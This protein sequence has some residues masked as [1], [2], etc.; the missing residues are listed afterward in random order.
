MCTWQ[1]GSVGLIWP[2]YWCSRGSGNPSADAE[3][4]VENSRVQSS[5]H[6]SFRSGRPTLSFRGGEMVTDSAGVFSR[7]T[8]PCSK[9]CKP[10]HTKGRRQRE[11]ERSLSSTS[12][13]SKR[14]EKEGRRDGLEGLQFASRQIKIQ[15][16]PH[17]GTAKPHFT[18]LDTICA[19]RCG[20]RE[21]QYTTLSLLFFW[22]SNSAKHNCLILSSIKYRRLNSAVIKMAMPWHVPAATVTGQWPFT[23]PLQLNPEKKQAT[24]HLHTENEI[25]LGDTDDLDMV[26]L[27]ENQCSH[28]IFNWIP[29]SKINK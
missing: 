12:Q 22:K 26:M 29:H 17:G 7:S 25:C 27:V 1:H 8:E 14:V 11:R 10:S 19:W 3:Q 4:G 20:G 28:V 2:C 23:D 18:P 13:N 9:D 16:Q 5:G 6:C 24:G 15:P 21:G